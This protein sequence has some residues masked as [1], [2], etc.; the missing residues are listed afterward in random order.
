MQRGGTFSAS[1]GQTARASTP[2]G[3]GR[4]AGHHRPDGHHVRHHGT[5]TKNF[6][7]GEVGE[8]TL[9][10]EGMELT[11]EPGLSFLIYAAE[12]ASSSRERLSLLASWAASRDWPEHPA[13]QPHRVE[14]S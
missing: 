4:R 1:W 9:T 11:A 7:H 10:Y 8:L 3:H 6:H 12:P 5:G 13:L 14:T 2:T